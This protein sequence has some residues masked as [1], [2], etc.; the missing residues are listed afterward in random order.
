MKTPTIFLCLLICIH[1]F[2]QAEDEALLERTDAAIKLFK[3]GKEKDGIQALSKLIDANPKDA[4]LFSIRAQ[5]RDGQRD[6]E[7]AILD[8]TAALKLAPDIV[9]HYQSRGAANFRAGNI[10]ASIKD[11]DK[12]IAAHP[13]QAPYHWQRGISHYYAGRF[14][15]GTAQFELH[16]TVNPNDVENSVFHF[17]CKAPLVGVEKAQE[18][19]IPIKNDTRIPMMKV[20]EMYAGKATPEEVLKRAHEGDPPARRLKNQLFYAH[21]YIGLYYEAL[22]KKEET[23][24]YIKLAATKYFSPHYMGDVARVHWEILQKRSKRI[25]GQAD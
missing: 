24:K 20:L 7:N 8:Y 4:S 11:F 3:S 1:G 13:E 22:R 10:E 14:K 9:N 5:M 18:S 2:V 17:I 15:D 21:L 23:A 25:E 12:Y 6:F 19:I 16:K